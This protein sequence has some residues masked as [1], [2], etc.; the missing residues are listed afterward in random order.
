M[1]DSREMVSL[2]GQ[3]LG[4]YSIDARLEKNASFTLYRAVWTRDGKESPVAIKLLN[5]TGKTSSEMARFRKSFELVRSQAI[6]GIVN[7]Y[8]LAL[9]DE[10]PA[11]VMELFEGAPLKEIKGGGP[12]PLKK[13][14]PMAEALS[15]TLGRLH[16]KNIVHQDIRPGNILIKEDRVKLANFGFESKLTLGNWDEWRP[17]KIEESLFYISPELT[18]RMNRP[19]DYRTDLYSLGVI[20]YEMVTGCVPFSSTDPMTIIHS[21]MAIVPA[22]PKAKNPDIPELLS[23]MIM[24]LLSKNSEDRYQNGYGL[25]YDLQKCREALSEK[26]SIDDFKPAQRDIPL[27]YHIPQVMVGRQQ[28]LNDLLS[29]FEGITQGSP[30]LMLVSGAPGIGKSALVNEIQKPIIAKRGYFLT[31]KYDQF[32]KDV[33]YSAI[34]HAFQKL[35]RQILSEGEGR[36][37]AWVKE[38]AAILGPNGRVITDVIPGVEL[39]L[40]KQPDIPELGPE[41]TRNRF[42]KVFS[43]FVSVF[44]KRD[45][46]VV[47]F[48]DDLQWA[49]SASLKLLLQ[50]ATDADLKYM[51]IICAY[52]D[53]E[54]DVTHPFAHTI[55]EIEK[56]GIC[57]QRILIGPLD[58]EN[59][60]YLVSNFLRCEP[61]QSLELSRMIHQKTGGNPFFINQFLKTLYEN[62]FLTLDPREGWAWDNQ[63]IQGMEVTDNVVTLMTQKLKKLQKRTRD[64]LTICACIGNRFD[65]DTIS[66]IYEKPLEETLT[67]MNEAIDEGLI[68]L[69]GDIY[70]FLHDRIQEAAYS[71]LSDH[72]RA[73]IHYRI[74][75]DLLKHTTDETLFDGVLYIVSHLNASV[76]MIRDQVEKENLIRLNLIAAGKSNKSTA[77]REGLT[78]LDVG[79][80]LLSEKA[81]ETQYE[82]A[83]KLHI[84]AANAAFLTGEFDR[85]DHFASIAMEKARSVLEQTEIYKIQ[86]YAMAARGMHETG[87][88][89]G[90]KALRALGVN[91]PPRPNKLHL[92]R[93][94]VKVKLALRGKTVESL[95]KMPDMTDPHKIAAMDLMSCVSSSAFMNMPELY[96]LLVFERLLLTVKYGINDHSQVAYVSYGLILAGIL[97]KAVE[98][99]RFGKL[100]VTLS[101]RYPSSRARVYCVYSVFVGHWNEPISKMI[102]LMMDGYHYSLETGEYEFGAL[103]LFGHCLFRFFLGEHLDSL[104]A[105]A[106]KHHQSI[107]KLKQNVPLHLNMVTWQMARHLKGSDP[108]DGE[109]GGSVFDKKTMVPILKQANERAP[110]LSCYFFSGMLLYLFNFHENAHQAF[111]IGDDYLSSGRSTFS[112]TDYVFFDALNLLAMIGHFSG[113]EQGR[114]LRKIRGNIHALKKWSE[115]SPDN[116]LSKY[117]L[118]RAEYGAYKGDIRKA[119]HFF[120]KAIE[121]AEK[122]PS[123]LQEG[124]CHERYALF[125]RDMDH[126]SL[127]RHYW[128]RALEIYERWGA[129]GKVR[130]MNGRYPEYQGKKNGLIK[131]I[132]DDPDEMSALGESGEPSSML[133]ENMDVLSIIRTSQAISREIDLDKLLERIMKISMENA[134]ASKGFFITQSDTDGKLY[135][136]AKGSTDQGVAFVKSM[137]VEE[138]RDLSVSI[139]RYVLQTMESLVIGDA[140]R[141]ETFGKDPYVMETRCRSILCGP[142]RHKGRFFGLIY[143]ENN[144]IPNAF[145]PERMRILQIFSS[146]AAISMENY[147]LLAEREK[148]IR[149]E[150]EMKFAADLQAKLVPAK[151]V[152]TGFDI[153]GYMKPADEVG[154]DYYDV[155]PASKEGHPDWIVIGDVSGHG[156]QAGVIMLMAQTSIQLMIQTD[157]LIPPAHLISRIDTVITRNIMKMKDSKYMTITA[158]AIDP[159]TGR[160]RYAGLHQDI[161]VYRREKG[162]VEVFESAGIWLGLGMAEE[163]T[164][165]NR[166]LFLHPGDTM[167]L[168][169]DGLTEA[170]REEHEFLEQERLVSILEKTGHLT[171][172]DM[173]D[174]IIERLNGYTTR[175]D[176][177]MLILKR[178]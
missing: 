37:E 172:Q 86:I 176:V 141:D 18:G 91:L 120:N 5:V 89:L 28:N 46:P 45:H 34:V 19:V 12:M 121:E 107:L 122:I 115:S 9:I 156:M 40:G 131:N 138:S 54:V 78:Y 48:L 150:T 173:M 163:V 51:F 31:G 67:D 7:M 174:A 151:P 170:V 69:E 17:D 2:A 11:L 157:P 136:Q 123:L 22:P 132:T 166:E 35:I 154:G 93:G 49:D 110:I 33:P 149:L 153:A 14:L 125:W 72:E 148:T 65:L 39:L 50:L 25:L 53:T 41:E 88:K 79:I 15:E 177:S 66:T 96:P 126:A 68:F 171:S 60:N 175:D 100:A 36:K 32:K 90:I 87:L 38:L 119:I 47:L 94:L 57:V 52:R 137:P 117:F 135:I 144:L 152:L 162:L 76:A 21:H 59:I 6:D 10:K 30:S 112:N 129:M 143:L 104:D 80:S 161:L 118:L 158:F 29:A 83:I 168:F 106:H 64:I 73:D 74:G 111:R 62:H 139:I 147:R 16:A 109:F 160:V 97:G 142:I 1:P 13:F 108:V 128:Q 124:L 164:I 99:N 84:G 24:K 81:W 95:L 105:I 3:F 159:K 167:L 70:K 4:T 8:E 98:G 82:Y 165:E 42:N 127:A 44:A 55:D 155:I 114:I 77:Y 103:N 56:A 145:T 92:I 178:L 27:K 75:T 102:D 63:A 20:F 71:L 23:D 133:A 113:L 61:F 85:M 140:E 26:K 146:Q 58:H 134:G 116:Y 101:E 43:G 169:T 130:Q